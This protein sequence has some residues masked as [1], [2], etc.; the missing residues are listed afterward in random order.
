M[1]P[2]FSDAVAQPGHSLL[3]LRLLAAG[4]DAVREAYDRHDDSK[5]LQ[6]PYAA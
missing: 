5:I 1:K 3:L 4:E 6:K 2:V